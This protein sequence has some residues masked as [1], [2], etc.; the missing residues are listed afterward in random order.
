LKQHRSKNR[1][2]TRLRIARPKN[3]ARIETGERAAL[4]QAARRI[5][6]PKNRARIETDTN[7]D[8]TRATLASPG[9]KT[10]RGL[11]HF[12]QVVVGDDTALHRPA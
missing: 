7:A 8:A 5:A 3:R 6:R 12:S 4:D 9:L 2:A 1:H 11:K 10:G